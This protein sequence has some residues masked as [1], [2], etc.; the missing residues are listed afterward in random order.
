MGTQGSSRAFDVTP[1]SSVRNHPL[2]P[3]ATGTKSTLVL[4]RVIRE[5]RSR[6]AGVSLCNEPWL[7]YDLDASEYAALQRDFRGDA[8]ADK[9]R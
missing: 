9:V 1:P 4:S 7:E 2:T 3:P 5:I 6:K 8:F